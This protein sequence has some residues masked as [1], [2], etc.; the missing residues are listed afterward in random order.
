MISMTHILKRLPQSEVE[1]TITVQEADYKK[2]LLPAAE[3][4]SM[5]ANL[6]GFR[7][8]K[9]PY[10]LLVREV[11]AAAILHEALE[12]IVKESFFAAIKEEK[13]ETIGMPKVEV[14]KLAPGNEVEYTAT[15]ALMPK[16]TLPDFKKIKIAKKEAKITPEKLEETLQALRGMQ[17]KEVL[18]DG[19]ATKNDKLIIDMN[20]KR[21]GVPVDGGQAKDYQ[22]YLSEDHYIPGFNEAL[23]GVKK[24]ETKEFT[25]SFPKDH[26]QKQLAGQDILFTVTVKEMYERVL[27]ELT[28]EFAKVLGKETLADLKA[29]LEDNAK[30]DAEKRAEQETEVEMLNTVVEKTEFEEVPAVIVDAEKEKIFF[31]LKRDLERNGITIEQ[32]LSDIKKNEEEVMAG[33]QET[34]LRRAKAALVSRQVAIEEKM[35]LN[36]EEID[37]EIAV[38]KETYKHDAEAQKN[39]ARPE[40]RDTIASA[41]QNR[42]VILLLKERLVTN[43]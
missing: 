11:G 19:I 17:A 12:S 26:Y 10:E 5:R 23:I 7:P 24:G 22:V 36:E 9:A 40:I 14:K 30:K 33:F 8:G 38:M 18:K 4:I 16:V 6:K 39:L 20:M 35:T 42:K 3:R 32:Y 29:L 34:A 15:V 1:L 37:A 2:H 25:L 43:G 41:M 31:E 21:E 27:P 13:L 28:D